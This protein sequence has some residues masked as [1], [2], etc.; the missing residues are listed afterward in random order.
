MA[1]NFTSLDFESLKADLI[2]YIKESD[3]FQDY[4]FGGSALN[5]IAGLLAYTTL[6]QNY[7]LNMTTQE[8]YLSSAT[9][10][11]NVVAIAKSLNYIPH[12]KQ[13]A[14]INTSIAFDQTNPLLLDGP[15]EIPST[16]SFLVNGVEFLTNT[17]Y[18]IYDSDPIDILLYQRSI[19]TETYS[20]TGIAKELLYGFEID[21]RF[22]SITVDGV[23]WSQY[24]NDI[25]ANSTSDIYFID[26]NLNN[27][28]EVTFGD[29]IIGK[30]PTIGSEIVVT[31]GV[32]AGSAGNDLSLIVLNQTVYSGVYSYIDSDCTI[33]NSTSSAGTEEETIQSIKV[34]APKFYEAQ[35][36]A[37]TKGDYQVLL[38]GLSFIETINI[39]DGAEANPP[40]YGTVFGSVKPVSGDDLLTTSQKAEIQTHIKQFMPLTLK[41]TLVDPIY[42]YIT[43]T[44]TVYYYSRYSVDSTV[45]RSEL[46]SLITAYFTND[47]TIEE[48][49][50]KYSR[51][52]EKIDSVDDVSNNLTD[53]TCHIKF[54]KTVSTS[55]NYIFDLGNTIKIN[56]IDNEYIKDDG[57]GNIIQ[58]STSTVIGG[59][60]YT[61]GELNFISPEMNS[62]DNIVKFET[63]VRDIYFLKNSLPVLYQASYIFEAI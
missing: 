61:T 2:A 37:V 52:I 59:I 7:Y 10:Y 18:N 1:Y 26:N 54:D 21:D 60:D 14:K 41:F 27:K 24:L 34:N 22:I 35:N 4:E 51:L 30:T 58:K 33:A 3:T 20:F 12:R 45:I 47:L 28:L 42:I 56:S 29:N 9:I 43:I 31:Y 19:N 6:Q 48:T 46:D 25:D 17:S 38:K 36:R 23:I 8:L 5:S 39:W 55:N 62:I 15:I 32:T 53:I 13:S 11:K 40:V 50:L 63:D 16:C 44:S 49:T 57:L